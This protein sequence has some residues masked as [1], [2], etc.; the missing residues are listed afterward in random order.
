MRHVGT[1]GLVLTVLA[2]AGCGSSPPPVTPVE[3]TI[4]LGKKPAENLLVYFVANTSG[5]GKPLGG[6]GLSDAAGKFVIKCDDGRTGLPAG[7]YIV[8]VIDNNLNVEEGVKTPKN[9]VNVKYSS[10][11]DVNPLKVNIPGPVELKLDP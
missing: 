2:L 3:G 6:A 10:V 9:R 1:A 5:A 8:T 11:G 4:Y 7:N